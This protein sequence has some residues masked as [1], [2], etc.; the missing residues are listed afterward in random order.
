MIEQLKQAKNWEERYRLI[1]QAGKNLPRPADD[2]LTNMQPISGCEAQ[3]WFQIIPQNDRTF[4][5]KAF[6]EARIMNGLLWLLLEKINGKNTEEL[7]QFDLSAFFTEL[8]IAQRLSETR[9]N[10]L[11]QIAQQLKQ[12]CI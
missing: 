4:Q 5:F 6:S 8:G 9:L 7:S 2:E 11:N 3:L 12:Q 1:I 10:G